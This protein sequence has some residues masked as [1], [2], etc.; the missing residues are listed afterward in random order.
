LS[1]RAF[2]GWEEDTVPQERTAGTAIAL[3]LEQLQTVDMTLDRA[4][5]PGQGEPRCD[6]REIL[7]QALGKA[8]ERLNPA[9]RCLG[10]P[11]LQSVAPALP[12]KRQKGLAQCVGLPNGLVHLTQLVNI[13]LGILRPLDFGAYP[14][15]R[16]GPG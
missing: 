10:Y 9:G 15:E 8:G 6:G 2:D 7:P 1:T 5:A 3:A 14:G 4:I 11:G 16:N 12:H 13:E